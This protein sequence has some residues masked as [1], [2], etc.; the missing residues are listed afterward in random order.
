MS[1]AEDLGMEDPEHLFNDDENDVES[2]GSKNVDESTQPEKSSE[3]ADGDDKYKG[4]SKR[5]QR[6][7][8]K[9]ERWLAHKTEK[10]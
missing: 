5:M 8:I 9:H 2:D 10:R 3:N 4:L 6:K 7:M 1:W